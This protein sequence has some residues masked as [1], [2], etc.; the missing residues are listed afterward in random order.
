VR[1][2]LTVRRRLRAISLFGEASAVISTGTGTG[3]STGM[4]GLIITGVRG[5][6]RVG[7]K[8]T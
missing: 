1:L 2:P 7:G 5:G 8:E 6:V 4:K 3:T